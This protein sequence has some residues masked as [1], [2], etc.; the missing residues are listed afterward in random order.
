MRWANFCV[1]W[2]SRRRLHTHLNP[3]CQGCQRPVLLA[4]E[5]LVELR[6]RGV[7]MQIRPGR[8][9]DRALP[10]CG[11]DPDPFGAVLVQ[12]LYLLSEARVHR[13]RNADRR[14]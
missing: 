10:V 6:Q 1:S 8:T 5:P 14:A 7:R 2:A 11:L 12:N 13:K 3:P 9:Q 4:P